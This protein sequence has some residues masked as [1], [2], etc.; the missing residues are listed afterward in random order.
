MA[1]REGS[2]SEFER[3]LSLARYLTSEDLR[4]VRTVA[5]VPRAAIGHAVLVALACEE[6]IMDQDAVLG[7]AGIDESS[8][9]PTVR[10][11]YT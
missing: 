10:G 6:I 7:D 11:G 4:R 9:G 3:A 1:G 2:G 5:Y 8:I